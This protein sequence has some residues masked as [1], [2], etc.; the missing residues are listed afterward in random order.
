VSADDK[1]GKVILLGLDGGTWR[2]LRPWVIEGD[3]PAFRRMMEEGVTGTLESTLPPTSGPAWASFSTGKNPGKHGIYDF[4]TIDEGAVRINSSSDL[5]CN[6]F[7]EILSQQGYRNIIVGLPLSFPPRHDF[8]GIM[9]SDFVYPRNAIFPQ[10]KSRYVDDYQ[11]LPNFTLSTKEE[12]LEEFKKTAVNR[13]TLAKELMVNEAWDLFFLWYGESDWFLHS[14]W[15]DIKNNTAIGQQAKQI[16]VIFDD[17][18]N[19]LLDQMNDQYL[20]IVSDHGFSDLSR[21]INLNRIFIDGEL[22]K[23]RYKDTADW[24]VVHEHLKENVSQSKTRSLKIPTF[25]LDLIKASPFAYRLAMKVFRNMFGEHYRSAHKLGIDFEHSKAFTLS[26]LTYGVFVHNS[27]GDEKTAL[28]GRLMER[29]TNLEYE[30][31]RVFQQILQRD[32]VYSGPYVDEAPDIMLKP[33]G[34][35]IGSNLSN[36]LSE[37]LV[38][39]Y[40]E[41]GFHDFDGVFLCRGP[42]T[43]TGVA[44]SSKV[45]LYDL[46]PTILHLFRTPIP[47]DVDGRVLFEL[48]ADDS[49]H[50]RERPTYVDPSHYST[51]ATPKA[52]Y[53]A[54]E[55]D[56]VKERLRRLGYL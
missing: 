12:L 6:A 23:T 30:G 2:I 10:S 11:I 13:T 55:E 54:Q 52:E 8:K 31:A 27:D 21:K 20:F 46:A 29:L 51:T 48:F 5:G 15:L 25:L 4:V 35:L 47:D 7:Y 36:A 3:L 32:D 50:N 42:D 49:A 26:C 17:F 39:R 33:N 22:L 44:L 19:W 45:S 28:I 40:P 43:R 53:T 16:Y 38:E 41:G 24:E 56:D 18:L 1:S 9:I 14:F 34:F 37:N